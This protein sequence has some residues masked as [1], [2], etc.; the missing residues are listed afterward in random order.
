MS[1]YE[2]YIKKGIKA[3]PILM[4]KEQEYI[5]PKDTSLINNSI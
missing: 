4:P 1:L 5:I 3:E 2:L